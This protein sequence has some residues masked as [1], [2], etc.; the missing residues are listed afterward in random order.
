MDDARLS[1]VGVK[2]L[3]HDLGGFRRDINGSNGCH[4]VNSIDGFNV[5]FVLP[6]LGVDVTIELHDLIIVLQFKICEAD[7]VGGFDFFDG[8]G[9]V[10]N[11]VHSRRI[12]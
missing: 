10:F 8:K 9:R 5:H 11:V 3:A 7:E 12:N 6:S 4:L 2:G 1:N